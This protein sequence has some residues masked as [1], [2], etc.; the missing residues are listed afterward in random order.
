MCLMI[1]TTTHYYAPNYPTG[2]NYHVSIMVSATH[3]CMAVLNKT[4]NVYE[5]V[6]K[7]EQG[8]AQLTYAQLATDLK[9]LPTQINSAAAQLFKIGAYL[10]PNNTVV[11]NDLN[12]TNTD[13]LQLINATLHYNINP[14]TLDKL[15]QISPALMVCHHT[16]VAVYNALTSS[17][18]QPNQSFVTA[19][20]VGKLL[21]VCVIKN[22]M[23]TLS[24]YYDI[25]HDDDIVYYILFAYNQLQLTNTEV[26]LYLYANYTYIKIITDKLVNFV[27]TIHSTH[28]LPAPYILDASI[29]EGLI[30]ELYPLLTMY[31]CV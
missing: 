17:V 9:L 7:Y 11:I 14:T 26:E 19:T 31:A 10:L 13:V 25:K 12:T 2:N 20:L 30:A 21:H 23:F 29:D 4:N 6:I 8:I 15:Q 1:N 22:G 28:T 18:Q 3:V 24:N 5:C 27:Q 16:Q